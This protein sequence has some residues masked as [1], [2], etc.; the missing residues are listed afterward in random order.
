MADPNF[1][2]G[3]GMP[4]GR[5]GFA[6]GAHRRARAT[7]LLSR[8]AR[9]QPRTPEPL[10]TT[11]AVFGEVATTLLPTSAA[12]QRGEVEDLL[13]LFPGQR[14]HWR[15]RPISLGISAP[16]AEGID[17]TLA[18]PDHPAVRAIGTVATRALVVGGR[19]LQSSA[20]GTVTR[21]LS[22]KRQP[23]SHYLSRVG[24]LEVITKVT[25]ETGDRLVEGFLAAR[26]GAT[27]LDLTSVTDRLLGQVSLHEGLDHDVPLRGGTTRLRWAARVAPG[28]ARVAF[29]L[30][31]DR[32][33]T[34]LVSVP[35]EAD[36]AAAQRF[37]E[38]LAVHDWLLTAVASAIERADLAGPGNSA[39]AEILAPVL[40]HLAHLWV[41]GAH[42]PPELRGPWEQ[43]QRDPDFT[44]DWRRSVDHL[45]NRM[46]VATW[47]AMRPNRV[48]STDG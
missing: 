4:R 41:P 27:G 32:Q 40:H 39:A 20:Q 26:V 5:S 15:E 22:D 19:V 36:L 8:S 33:R 1:S 10:P 12:L 35:A 24:V 9:A 42:T 46:L 13:G 45:R 6:G 23:W 38:D 47:N 18:A 3:S 31:D 48:G 11:L 7:R 29:R 16:G 34:V 43:L 37:C 30:L 14:A 2:R 21:A 25:G 17:C 44:A 28:A